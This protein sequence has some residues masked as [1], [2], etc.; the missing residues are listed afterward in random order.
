M[1]ENPLLL[2]EK[3]GQSIWLDYTRRDLIATGA[4]RRLIEDEGLRGMTS[5]PS[6]FK[7]AIL[8]SDHYGEDIRA[9]AVLGQ[10]PKGIHEGLGGRDAQAAAGEFRGVS[11]IKWLDLLI[12]ALSKRT[13][14]AS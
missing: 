3:I 14:S 8:N 11:F 2:L 9:M 1:S 4:L 5:N 6:I 7:T 12:V 10:N 13:A